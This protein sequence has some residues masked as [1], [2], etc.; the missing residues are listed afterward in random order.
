MESKSPRRSMYSVHSPFFGSIT[1]TPNDTL[2]ERLA[3]SGIRPE[4]IHHILGQLGLAI[5]RESELREAEA[6]SDPAVTP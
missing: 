5:V 3:H 6:G 1:F 4:E 2:R